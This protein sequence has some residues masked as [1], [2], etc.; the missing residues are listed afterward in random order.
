MVLMIIHQISAGKRRLPHRP[1][2]QLI[3]VVYARAKICLALIINLMRKDCN[4]HSCRVNPYCV[5]DRGG[6]GSQQCCGTMAKIPL[7]PATDLQC[8][9][10][11]KGRFASRQLRYQR[12]EEKLRTWNLTKM[13]IARCVKTVLGQKGKDWFLALVI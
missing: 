12:T 9:Q 1:N 10:E 6:I 7:V 8:Q 5:R 13:P 2:F 4:L 11:R 3:R